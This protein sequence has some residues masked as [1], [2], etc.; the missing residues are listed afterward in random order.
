[1]I[2]A[3]NAGEFK[4]A[5]KFP[6]A[7]QLVSDAREAVDVGRGY[8]HVIAGTDFAGMDFPD[9]LDID[10]MDIRK[11]EMWQ[12]AP[13]KELSFFTKNI[14]SITSAISALRLIRQHSPDFCGRIKDEEL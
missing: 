5:K 3:T 6:V 1:M 11:A 14:E 8:S 10:F 7:V 4:A 13:E 12:V 2:I 9:D